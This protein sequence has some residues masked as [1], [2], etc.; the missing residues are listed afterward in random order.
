LRGTKLS[1]CVINFV[2]FV[3]DEEFVNLADLIETVIP[4]LD[5]NFL[6]LKKSYTV[7]R[8]IAH[9][10]GKWPE[11]MGN[12]FYIDSNYLIDDLIDMVKEKVYE[13]YRE[14]NHAQEYF[15]ATEEFAQLI[16]SNIDR[17]KI[18]WFAIQV[19]GKVKDR[20][21]AFINNG[22][23]FGLLEVVNN[24]LFHMREHNYHVSSPMFN[25]LE[26]YDH[27]H[28]Q[29]AT[30]LFTIVFFLFIIDLIL[31]YSM[32][33]QDVEERTYEFAMLKT[34]GFRDSSLIVLLV[35]Q[36]IFFAVPATCIG[37]LLLWIFTQAA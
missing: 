5:P 27:M 13:T 24:F 23:H 18:N 36:T 10:F 8:E 21:D 16:H 32:M 30:I 11:V 17:K 31:I 37:F 6:M 22:K 35:I 26:K 12:G 14:H 7:K 19:L 34:L 2:D 15:N 1:E 33:L 29:L 28:F 25:A 20:Q 4:C 3:T 9:S